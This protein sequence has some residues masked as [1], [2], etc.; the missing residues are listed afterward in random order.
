M[1]CGLFSAPSVYINTYI[2]KASNKKV[3]VYSIL[4]FALLT[5][6]LLFIPQISAFFLAIPMSIYFALLLSFI[7]VFILQNTRGARKEL[8]E[9]KN[10]GSY[11]LFILPLLISVSVALLELYDYF[12]LTNFNIFFINGVRVNYLL[13]GFATMILINIVIIIVDAINQK[14]ENKNVIT[15]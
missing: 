12:N 5:L 6:I 10:I 1:S 14:R 4:L 8:E 13:I 2:D 9:N 3:R 15:L 7:L 11:L